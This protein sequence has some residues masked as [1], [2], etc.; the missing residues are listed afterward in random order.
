MVGFTAA[1]IAIFVV[2][3]ISTL[4]QRGVVRVV[5]RNRRRR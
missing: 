4:R 1:I 2:M 5:A 3:Q